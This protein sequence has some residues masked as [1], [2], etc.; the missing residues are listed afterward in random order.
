MLLNAKIAHVASG[1]TLA[2]VFA[3]TACAA[4]VN[5][6]TKST[7][8]TVY[9]ST[10]G[11]AA[12]KSPPAVFTDK[13][14][15]LPPN[16]HPAKA[17]FVPLALAPT[18]PTNRITVNGTTITLPMRSA[19][20]VQ[21][22]VAGNK[23]YWVSAGAQGTQ[24]FMT[25][26]TQSAGEISTSLVYATHPQGQQPA[27]AIRLIGDNRS[28][29]FTLV[30][31]NHRFHDLYTVNDRQRVVRLI[32][33][34][35]PRNPRFYARNSGNIDLIA[36]ESA[37]FPETKLYSLSHNG[38]VQSLTLPYH[39]VQTVTLNGNLYLLSGSFAYQM[40]NQGAIHTT[41]WMPPAMQQTA[42]TLASHLQ[43][44]ELMLPSLAFQERQQTVY[45]AATTLLSPTSYTITLK[46]A[47]AGGASYRLTV[48][49][50]APTSTITAYSAW[51][52]TLNTL[53]GNAG[54]RTVESNTLTTPAK[55]MPAFFGGERILHQFAL[56][57]YAEPWIRWSQAAVTRKQSVWYAAWG[58]RGWLY[59]IGPL[60][61]PAD[62]ASKGVLAQY[63][64]SSKQYPLQAISPT[65]E[66]KI[67]L[68]W[69]NGV[70]TATKSSYTYAP[71]PGLIVQLNTTDDNGWIDLAN[72]SPIADQNIQ[73]SAQ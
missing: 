68:S 24:L 11:T 28:L 62:A 2:S 42:T 58:T 72:F 22:V 21:D 20:G 14:N 44:N 64:E 73:S 45:E 56:K 66:A 23:L 57:S 35:W 49:Q 32:V 6:A 10:T 19:K 55:K 18:S 31:Q 8:A 15:P 25:Q 52:N 16:A 43:G 37:T 38:T 41:V 67:L 46:P 65:G 53:I 60:A 36:C 1:V 48:Q 47:T 27:P 29:Y 40:T 69:Q 30:D 17:A 70:A 13:L 7:M 59:L 9:A 26:W 54:N 4:P 50:V 33:C 34:N 51:V 5:H 3:L 61:S 39:S 71:V 63:I 12:G